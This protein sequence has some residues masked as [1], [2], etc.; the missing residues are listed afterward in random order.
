MGIAL[1]EPGR[2]D[3]RDELAKF[4]NPP[5]RG[6]DAAPPGIIMSGN[7]QAHRQRRRGFT[8]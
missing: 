4:V 1:F 2:E 3:F 6:P 8:C 5:L 7:A